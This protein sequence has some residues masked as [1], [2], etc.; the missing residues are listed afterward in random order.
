VDKEI[1]QVING[2]GHPLIEPWPGDVVEELSEERVGGG[3]VPGSRLAGEVLTFRRPHS[4][5]KS[6]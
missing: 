6:P 3:K 1:G 4:A 2:S 5:A